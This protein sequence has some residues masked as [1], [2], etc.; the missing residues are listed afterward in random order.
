[1]PINRAAGGREGALSVVDYEQKVIRAVKSERAPLGYLTGEYGYG[2]TSTALHV[3]QSAEEANLVAVPPFQM[4]H[5]AD[6]ITAAHGWLRYRLT[7]RNPKLALELDELHQQVTGQN[8]E[9]EARAKR[10]NA[11][12]LREWVERGRFILDLQPADFIRFFHRAT[13]IV[14]RGGFDGW[15]MLPDE[16]Q[17]YIGPAMLRSDDPIAPMFNLT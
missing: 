1:V 10:V 2:K 17:Q 8:L 9:E 12:T 7:A 5:L 16:I 6:L 13:E 11:E 15:L 3:W 14:Q 4:L